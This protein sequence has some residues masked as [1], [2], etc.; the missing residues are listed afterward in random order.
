MYFGGHIL[1]GDTAISI[2]LEG[3]SSANVNKVFELEKTVFSGRDPWPRTAFISELRNPCAVWFVAMEGE[4]LA[5]YGGG[6]CV[7][8]EFHLLNLA[9]HPGYR[10][11]GLARRI[12]DAVFKEG[13]R[14]N[15]G[16]VV[17]EVR[18]DNAD[19]ISLY[20]KI[21]FTRVASRLRYYSAGED[22]LVYI[23]RPGGGMEKKPAG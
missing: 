21:G 16:T 7:P 15:C 23:R 10:R 4:E 6:W 9:V 11:G 5:G 22:A 18:H 2:S 1:F 17:L 19:A 3:F 13:E 8:P 20:E 14:K 12:L